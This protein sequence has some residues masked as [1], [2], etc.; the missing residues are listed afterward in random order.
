MYMYSCGVAEAQLSFYAEFD[1]LVAGRQ[2]ALS[3]LK[4]Y[5]VRHILSAASK[6]PS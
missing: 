1:S 5:C 3:P 2:L 6:V 4:R